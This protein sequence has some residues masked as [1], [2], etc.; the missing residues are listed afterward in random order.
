M[1]GAVDWHSFSELLLQPHGWTGTRAPA[2]DDAAFK[3]LG[4][5]MKKDIQASR[6]TTYTSQRSWDLYMVSGAASDYFYST[7]NYGITIELSPKNGWELGG[8]A[9][10]PEY[11]LPVGKEI[12]P[13][14]LTYS[15]FCLNKPLSK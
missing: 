4:E 3:E 1:I 13:A 11:I 9:L 15:E 7:K 2:S 12:F 5:A 10:P 8:F 14:V 6:G